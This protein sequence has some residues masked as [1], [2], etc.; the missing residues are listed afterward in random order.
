MNAVVIGIYSDVPRTYV[1]LGRNYLAVKI[2]KGFC[3]LR[4]SLNLKFEC[5]LALHL[6]NEMNKMNELNEIKH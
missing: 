5:I 2:M 3:C 4:D 6:M 1:V